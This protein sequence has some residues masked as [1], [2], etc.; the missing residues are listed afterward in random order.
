[1]TPDSF[2]AKRIVFF[3]IPAHG[4][5]NPTIPV[6]RELVRRGHDVIYYSYNMFR[7]KIEATGAR[8]V[9]CEALM[10]ELDLNTI[11]V[12]KVGADLAYS[13]RML[14]NV[15]LALGPKIREEIKALTPDVIVADSL[16]YWAR[17]VAREK[18]IPLVSSTTTFAFNRA[19]GAILRPNLL[20]MLRLLMAA[21]AVRKQI[22]RLQEGGFGTKD[23]GSAFLNDNETDTIVYTSREFQP[24][25]ETFS[26]KIHFIGPSVPSRKAPKKDRERKL[27]YISL[28]TVVNKRLSFYRNCFAALRDMPVDVVMSV[29]SVIRI[30]ELGAI[31]DNFRV[32]NFVDQHEVL[33][34]A[35]LFLSHGG[36]NSVNES[37]YYEVPLVLFPQT[38]EQLGVARRV[39]ET[40]AGRLLRSST[41]RGIRTA[42]RDV[43]ADERYREGA[44]MISR[45]F[46]SCGGAAEGADVILAAAERKRWM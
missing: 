29:G 31:P 45:G 24:C 43:L 46:R 32:S 36:M 13:A 28:G 4:H 12:E 39:C 25:A 21:P 3:S 2:R 40:G 14:A 5:T 8:F 37:L 34:R 6:A 35:D 42:V 33:Q 9:S 26:E 41:A 7:G 38:G 17:C 30:E 27:V 22:R 19:S 1:M 20:G 10:P 15:T 44:S 16:A 23:M 11:E 18:E